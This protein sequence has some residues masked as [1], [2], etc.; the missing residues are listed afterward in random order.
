[1]N[2]SPAGSSKSTADSASNSS[3]IPAVYF[4][5]PSIQR[6]EHTGPAMSEQEKIER[7]VMEYDVV[8]VGGGPSGL[9]FAIRLK[10]L[11]PDKNICVLE[12][13]SAIGAHSLSGAVMEPGPL[14][15]LLPKWRDEYKGM[16]VPAT[17]DVFSILTKTG[18]F[19][20]MPH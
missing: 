18:S 15:K 17:E 10:Q 7:E 19:S 16:K 6:N 1:M 12:K 8:V 2:T 5:P 13:A 11:Q 20:P 9:A 3:S 14:D 4:R